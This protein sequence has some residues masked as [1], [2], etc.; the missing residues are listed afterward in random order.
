MISK[1]LLY[2][3][4]C[5]LHKYPPNVH[6]V[7]YAHAQ[8]GIS[9]GQ[10]IPSSAFLVVNDEEMTLDTCNM[11]SDDIQVEKNLNMLTLVITLNCSLLPTTG[12]IYVGYLDLVNVGGSYML[13]GIQFGKCSS[14]C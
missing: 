8:A 6:N 12:S 4:I 13:P 5:I 1:L 10:A 7:V 3:S 14:I 11:T 9:C 2:L